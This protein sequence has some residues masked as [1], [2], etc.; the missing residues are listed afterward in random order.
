VS[1]RPA[2]ACRIST[3]HERKGSERGVLET[4]IRA[5]V[6]VTA[7]VGLA[8]VLNLCLDWP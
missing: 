7:T 5:A 8:F 3:M 2:N 1:G 6:F 4:L